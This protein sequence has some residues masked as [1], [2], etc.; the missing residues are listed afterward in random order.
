VFC[1]LHTYTGLHRIL[2]V[3]HLLCITLH[4]QDR[5]N[6]RFTAPLHRERRAVPP[7]AA[8]AHNTAWRLRHY[9][10]WAATGL[11]P[12]SRRTAAAE[13][14][15]AAAHRALA[16]LRH[17]RKGYCTTA[18]S[19]CVSVCGLPLPLLPSVFFHLSTRICLP[20]CRNAWLTWN[21]HIRWLRAGFECCRTSAA[22][23][24]YAAGF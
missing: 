22:R 8:G 16:A 15:G 2:V 20:P 1:A 5:K 6:T 24:P 7:R 21:C 18:S 10:R 23:K 9:A 4:V 13:H 17:Y 14:A 11:A 3:Y 19:A 12:T